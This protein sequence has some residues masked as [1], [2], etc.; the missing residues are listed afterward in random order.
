MA[1]TRKLGN[2]VI[3]DTQIMLDGGS[4]EN[5]ITI[6]DAIEFGD[7]TANAIRL[8]EY[9]FEQGKNHHRRKIKH[10]LMDE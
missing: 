9:A 3:T 1:N 7:H 2:F 5:D 4:P 10:L 8:F 6:V